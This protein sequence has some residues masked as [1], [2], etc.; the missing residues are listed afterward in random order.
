MICT[1]IQYINA[2][3]FESIDKSKKCAHI[4]KQYI[5]RVLQIVR[6]I[7]N[8]IQSF[9]YILPIHKPI[10]PIR[11]ESEVSRIGS[12]IQKKGL[13]RAEVLDRFA[14]SKNGEH[15]EEKQATY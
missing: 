15:D 13:W 3:F 4:S 9:N 1:L 2:L 11:R 14:N 7:I 12:P 6:I 8:H 10:T 5:V